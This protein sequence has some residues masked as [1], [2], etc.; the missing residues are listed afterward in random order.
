MTAFRTRYGL[1]KWQVTSF[2]LVNAPSTFQK[3]INWALREHL[4]ETCS[5]YM[6][7][8]LVYT[9]G[10]IEEHR[11]YVRTILQKLENAGLYL[12]IAKCEFEVTTTKYLGYIV[13]AEEGIAMD[14]EKVRAIQSWKPPST[15]KG[16]RSFLGFANFY[17]SFIPGF[18]RIATP[19]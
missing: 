7:D 18:L 14:P 19:I 6:D 1:F 4:D 9:D 11:E 17:R 12:D 15:V 8:V 10:P 3:Y 5:A 13:Q 2:G 16:V